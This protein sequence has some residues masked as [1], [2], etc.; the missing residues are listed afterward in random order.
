MISAV[1][2]GFVAIVSIPESRPYEILDRE[3]EIALAKSAGLSPW[4]EE[5]TIYVLGP[6]GYSK[7]KEGTNG[8]ACMVGRTEPGTRWPVMARPDFSFEIREHIAFCF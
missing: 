8:F 2:L 3:R 5:A 4:N 1:V 7:A 6:E